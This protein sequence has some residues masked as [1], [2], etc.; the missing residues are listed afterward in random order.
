MIDKF[1]Q[2]HTLQISDKSV[3]ESE[4]DAITKNSVS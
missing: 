1:G 2:D 4:I 3:L